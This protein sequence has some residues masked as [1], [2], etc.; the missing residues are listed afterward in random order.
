MNKLA[1]II[2]LLFILFFNKSYSQVILKNTDVLTEKKFV[3]TY[4]ALKGIKDS[5]AEQYRKLF[6]DYWKFTPEIVFTEPF[7]EIPAEPDP[8]AL[9]IYF[10]E[11]RPEYANNTANLK[12]P[13]LYSLVISTFQKGKVILGTAIVKDEI[14]EAILSTERVQRKVL[15]MKVDKSPMGYQIRYDGEGLFYNWKPGYIKN[16]LQHLNNVFSNPPA[17]IP[18]YMNQSPYIINEIALKRIAND[19]LYFSDKIN[20]EKYPYNKVILTEAELNN[21]ILK[22]ETPFYYVN[23]SNWSYFEYLTIYNAKTGEIVYQVSRG[24][25]ERDQVA[26]LVK[27]MNKKEPFIQ[28]GK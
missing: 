4:V 14:A 24:P 7:N 19:T 8:N 26:K 5:G 6:K 18:S 9:Y 23:K 28:I 17:K 13:P 11:E 15:T 27:N 16:Y 22:S 10:K 21:K 25:N 20:T 12:D 2:S 1:A 3:K